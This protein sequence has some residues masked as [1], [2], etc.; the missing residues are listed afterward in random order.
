MTIT[1][2]IHIG[3]FLV[4]NYKQ[5]IEMLDKEEAL[6]YAMEQAGV[7]EAILVSRLDEEKAY[8]DALSKEPEV[9]T[10]QME[11][12]QQLVNLSDRK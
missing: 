4:N 2:K 11:Y 3:T 8:L 9:E 1:D 12:Y 7:T 6:E 5:A 10:D